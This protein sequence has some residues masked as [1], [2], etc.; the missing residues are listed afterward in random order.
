MLCRQE[1]RALVP[2][3]FNHR[4]Y[5]P[6][7]KKAIKSIVVKYANSDNP[8]INEMV[9]VQKVYCLRFAMIYMPNKKEANTKNNCMKKENVLPWEYMYLYSFENLK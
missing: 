9:F 7:L 2:K 1:I 3:C 6:V 8:K 4:N 5:T